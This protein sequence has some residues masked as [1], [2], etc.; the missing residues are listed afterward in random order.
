[1]SSAASAM[2]ARG[3]APWPATRAAP[4][5]P[6]RGL[7]GGGIPRALSRRAASGAA[8]GDASP[9]LP[10]RGTNALQEDADGAPHVSVLMRQVL[11]CFEGRALRHYVDGTMGAGGHASAVVRA[12]P[13]MR[14]FVGFDV[15]PLAH[16]LAR[17]RLEAAAEDARRAAH[18]DASTSTSEISASTVIHTVSANFR[19]IRERLLDLDVPPVDGI[20]LDLGVSSMHLDLPERGFSFNDDGPLDMRMG[21]D[22]AVTAEEIVNEWPED[23]IARVLRDYGEEKHWRLLARRICERRADAPITTT[24]QLVAALGRVPGAKGG[25]SGNVHPAT[26]T[27]QGIRIAV[28]DELG[29]VEDVIPAAIESLAPGGRLAIISFHSLED[30]IVKEAFRRAAGRLPATDRPL[31]AW[32][33]QPEAPPKIVELVTRKPIV[34]DQDEVKANVRSRS[35]KLRVCEKL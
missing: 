35:A 30:R 27:F 32:E 17:P 31:S 10:P 33:P 24:R 22:A 3:F 1:M 23:E 28:N 16:A 25:R 21:P 8:S 9:A 14:A 6:S 11:E 19:D 7:G 29:A 12:H 5:R 4:P 2:T 15:D 18:A 34:A 20:L 13:E 26:R